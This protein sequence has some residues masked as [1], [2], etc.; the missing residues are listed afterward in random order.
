MAL[1]DRRRSR[2]LQSDRASGVP[3]RRRRHSVLRLPRFQVLRGRQQNWKATLGYS[4]EGSWV[5]NSA[6]IKGGK[7]YFATSDTELLRSLDA[8]GGAE[9]FTLDFHRWPMFSSPAIAGN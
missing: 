4:N 9:L 5:I 2:D 6:A 7:V 1:Q 3:R 8:K